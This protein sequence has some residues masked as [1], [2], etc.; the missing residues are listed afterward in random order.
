MRGRSLSLFMIAVALLFGMPIELRAADFPECA[1]DAYAHDV[2]GKQAWQN[3]LYDFVVRLRP[4]LEPV[5]KAG[6]N[7]QIA[8][9]E[10]GLARLKYL[11][12]SDMGRIVTDKS[13]STFRNFD[14]SDADKAAYLAADAS[15]ERRV[16]ALAV[17][18]NRND[19]Q[20]GWNALRTFIRV[21]ISRSPEFVALLTRLQHAENAVEEMLKGCR[22]N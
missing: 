1:I 4:D 16:G 8:L 9:A 3:G 19:S 20:S 22:Q 10:L 17:L 21:E 2:E 14:W 5:A 15:Y 11:A 13:I 6:R 7:L 12:M 18:R